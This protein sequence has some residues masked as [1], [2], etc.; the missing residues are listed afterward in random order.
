LGP[1][2]VVSCVFL[3]LYGI[4]RGHAAFVV[5]GFAM[6]AA[7]FALAYWIGFPETVRQ[8]VA[9]WSDPW[10]NGV[11]GGNHI[12]HGLWALSTGAAWGSGPGLGSPHAIP[13]GHTDFVL[14]AIGEELGFAGLVVIVAL[15]AL[16]CWRCLRVAI[17]APGDYSAFLAVG[18][19]LALVVQALVISGG[20]LGAV[21]LAGVVT[22]FL[23]FGRSSMLANAFAIGVVLAIAKRR[24]AVRPHLRQPIRALG[25]VLAAAAIGLTARAGWVQVVRADDFA[26]ASS[27]TEQADRGYRFEHNPRLL[28]AA[29]TLVRG[30]IYDRNGLPLATSRGDEAASIDAMYRAAGIVAQQPCDGAE[31]RCYPLGGFA[32]HV[33][34]D[35]NR[36]ANWAARNSSY[37]EREHDAQLKGYDDRARA[38]DVMNPRTGRRELAIRRD[39][40]ELLPLVRERYRP[41]SDAVHALLARN[42]DVH[43]SIDA[44][45]QLRA[46]IALRDR[47]EAGGQSHGAAVV[48]DASTGEV[49]ASISYPWPSPEDLKMAG[50]GLTA[51]S[52]PS[53]RLLDRARYG[54]YPPGSTFKL[55]VAGAALRAGADDASFACIR[56]PDGRVGNYV[57]GSARPVRDDPMDK[58]P[59]GHV[60]LRRGLIVSCNAYFAQLAQSLGPGPLLEAAS[61]FQIDLARSPTP[62]GLQ[63]TLPHAGYG[64]GQVVISPVKLA[65]ISASIAAGGKAP[66]VRSVVADAGKV[67]RDFSPGSG[68][69]QRFLTAAD[70]A[71]LARA[72][73]DVVTSGTGRSLATSPVPIAGKTGTAEVADAPAHSWFTGFA[74]YGATGRR[75]AFAVVVENAGYGARAAAPI[76]GELVAA[77]HEFGLIK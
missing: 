59:H 70:A 48:L 47:I 62:G 73:R 42:R 44:R 46:A 41:R 12:A 31:G 58:S 69:A 25:A 7:G 8:R 40:R 27:L 68:N 71:R 19:A 24:S 6:L 10:N 64:Q 38:V 33:I 50:H 34:G 30:T 5:T 20:L 63:P 17:R 23:S 16:V 76:A 15:Y 18:V 13:A 29:R 72:M 45:L 49:L 51:E 53:G 26:S 66:R 32:F 61:V 52:R 22:P 21:P 9:I 56:L 55:L 74:P 36:Q 35:W 54:L 3:A 14:A 11:S 75:I 77:A 60:D 43:T 39:F 1:A 65:R 67:G 37:V 4:G 57:R 28:A 2:L